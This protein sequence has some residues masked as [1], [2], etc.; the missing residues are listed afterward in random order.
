VQP[1]NT[2][3]ISNLRS[4]KQ[5]K[6]DTASAHAFELAEQ[7]CLAGESPSEVAGDYANMSRRTLAGRVHAIK[8]G[9]PRKRAIGR[10]TK[11]SQESEK[12]LSD[13]IVDSAQI[14]MGLT[15][16]QVA[17]AAKE[18]GDKQSPPVTFDGLAGLP[19][20]SWFAKP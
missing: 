20:R 6:R 1:N 12:T 3:F 15:R 19:G 13:F 17:L 10:S 8:Q 14:G 4:G 18:L 9:Q 5:K 16:E 2:C 11:L 7:R